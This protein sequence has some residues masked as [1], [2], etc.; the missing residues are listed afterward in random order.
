MRDTV[1]TGLEE[2]MEV[3]ARVTRYT[4]AQ[5]GPRWQVS[6]DTLSITLSKASAEALAQALKRIDIKD[7]KL[8]SGLPRVTGRHCCKVTIAQEG[9]RDPEF[10]EKLNYNSELFTATMRDE[11]ARKTSACR[12][13]GG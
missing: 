10:I 7:V 3:L 13:I 9:I 6:G 4:G 1:I 2:Q 12:S 5:D 8:E 11:I